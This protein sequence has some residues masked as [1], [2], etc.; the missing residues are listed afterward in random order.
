[1]TL[2][3]NSYLYS[4][5]VLHISFLSTIV[6][7]RQWKCHFMNSNIAPLRCTSTMEFVMQPAWRSFQKIKG[8][9]KQEQS[10]ANSST[11]K[12]PISNSLYLIPESLYQFQA[13]LTQ[14]VSCMAQLEMISFLTIASH[15]R[16]VKSRGKS[17]Y[18]RP[19]HTFFLIS[20]HLNLTL[21]V[22]YPS[23]FS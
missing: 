5:H 16:V 1:M 12:V 11:Q 10:Y 15:L 8:H 6:R 3:K 9:L 23:L 14:Q 22:I 20:L 7:V 4:M 2:I 19:R 13:S 21:S 17:P 18:V